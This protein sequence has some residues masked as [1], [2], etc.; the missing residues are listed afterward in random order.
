MVRLNFLNRVRDK[1]FA[2]L[3]VEH[4]SLL[5]TELAR[6][7]GDDH[8]KRVFVFNIC[9]VENMFK[10]RVNQNNSPQYL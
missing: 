8:G 2:A 3:A 4:T 10:I 1:A 7:R 9:R 5:L 6:A